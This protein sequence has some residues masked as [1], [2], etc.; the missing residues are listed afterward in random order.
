MSAIEEI[1][2]DHLDDGNDGELL[3]AIAR[4]QVQTLQELKE[5]KLEVKKTNG[6]VTALESRPVLPCAEKA[7]EISAI[8]RRVT[9][10]N[11]RAALYAGGL[12]VLVF[13]RDKIL[14]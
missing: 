14:P 2:K 9:A 10:L 5:I 11:I 8:A 3:R 12:A 6:R 1:I 7:R 13:F 4:A